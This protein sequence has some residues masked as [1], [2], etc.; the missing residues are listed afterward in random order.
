M[1]GRI[2]CL[3]YERRVHK[4]SLLEFRKLMQTAGEVKKKR[5]QILESE[6]VVRESI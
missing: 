2:A 5:A 6:R 4:T 1:L 3:R